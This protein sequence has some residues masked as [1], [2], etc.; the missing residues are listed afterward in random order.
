MGG[1]R[2]QTTVEW[3]GLVL[4]VSLAL[5]GLVAFGVRVPGVSLARS[6]SSKI[7]CAAAMADRCGDESA[8]VAA[9]GTEIGELVRHHMPTIGTPRR[10]AES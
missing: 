3:V 6:I 2:G 7:L 10:V 9:Y 5:A 8:L 1:E 4:L